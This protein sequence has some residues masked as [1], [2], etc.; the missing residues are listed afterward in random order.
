MDSETITTNWSLFTR[1]Y[2]NIVRTATFLLLGTLVVIVFGDTKGTEVAIAAVIIVSSLFAVIAG[3]NALHLVDS[4]RA[5]INDDNKSTNFGK[6]LQ[7]SPFPFFRA[8][9]ALSFVAV[10][11]TQLM[12]LF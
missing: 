6:A 5:D 7:S 11:I 1:N 9:S 12:V 3:D 8:T 2:F 4:L 10:A